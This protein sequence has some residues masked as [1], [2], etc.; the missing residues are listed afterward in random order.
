MWFKNVNLPVGFTVVVVVVVVVVVGNENGLS[1]AIGAESMPE[2]PFTLPKA[3]LNNEAI[4]I[5]SPPDCCKSLS[6]DIGVVATVGHP[7]NSV[8]TL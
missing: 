7:V 1:G 3:L 2:F 8:V 5:F 6:I 4:S